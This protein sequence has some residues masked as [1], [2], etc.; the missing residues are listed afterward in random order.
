MIAAQ[1]ILEGLP[2]L[3]PDETF[4]GLGAERIC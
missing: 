3:T 1:G 2:V 4:S